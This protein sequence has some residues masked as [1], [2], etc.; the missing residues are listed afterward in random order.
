[1]KL[2]KPD[3]LTVRRLSTLILLTLHLGTQ[4]FGQIKP[5]N[6]GL[7]SEQKAV[8]AEEAART[9]ILREAKTAALVV[10]ATTTVACPDGAPGDCIRTDSDII[11]K[12]QSLAD[13][14][15][16]WEYFEKTE[17]TEAEIFLSF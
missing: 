9:K 3:A 2:T 14:T 15:D 1:M 17:A 5:R 11:S 8:Q 7:T 6:N 16:I 10:R 13:G 4:S 12:V